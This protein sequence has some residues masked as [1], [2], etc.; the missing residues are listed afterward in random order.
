MVIDEIHEM[1]NNDAI[2]P[3]IHIMSKQ[4]R[5]KKFLG[6]SATIGNP[7]RIHQWLKSLIPNTELIVVN[8]RFFNLSRFVYSNNELIGISPFNVMDFN[9]YPRNLE[10]SFVTM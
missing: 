6:L 7:S 9:L 1:N 3:L 4:K 10:I 2:E 5:F 8:E